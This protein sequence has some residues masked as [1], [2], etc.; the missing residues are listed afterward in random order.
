MNHAVVEGVFFLIFF[1]CRLIC[2]KKNQPKNDKN[3]V[4]R[5]TLRLKMSP[6]TINIY[7]NS[8]VFEILSH[9]IVLLQSPVRPTIWKLP[10]SRYHRNE[11]TIF[12]SLGYIFNTHRFC[13]ATIQSL[14]A[15][16][17]PQKILQNNYIN[18]RSC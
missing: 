18:V 12:H 10:L 17:I 5:S 15:H 2:D 8:F 4:I 13:V 16:A 1:V 11:I 7:R 14:C 6:N 3:R 9:R